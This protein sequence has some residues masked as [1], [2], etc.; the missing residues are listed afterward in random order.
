MQ[1]ANFPDFLARSLALLARDVP[2]LHRRLTAQMKSRPVRLTIDGPAI[3][4]TSD[5]E[6]LHLRPADGPPPAVRLHTDASTILRMIAGESSL[7]DAILAD[8]VELFGPVADLAAFH[9]DLTLY[10]QA[11]VRCPAL[12][13]L[14]REF[15]AHTAER[16]PFHD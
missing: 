15:R 3:D 5:G 7:E 8:D 4:V 13:P 14:L 12:V 11:A 10:L 2:P 9:A 16:R 6:A 1:A